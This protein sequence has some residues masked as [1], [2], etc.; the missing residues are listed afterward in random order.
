MNLFLRQA[1]MSFSEE[2]SCRYHGHRS[3]L[4]QK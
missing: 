2:L 1:L 3:G 4:A